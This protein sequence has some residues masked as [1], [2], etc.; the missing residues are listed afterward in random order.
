MDPQVL[1]EQLFFRPL[2]I[3]RMFVQQLAS[4]QRMSVEGNLWKV[5]LKVESKNTSLI[6]QPRERTSYFILED[7]AIFRCMSRA[8]IY[9]LFVVSVEK[10]WEK[11]SFETN[12]QIILIPPHT[13][14]IAVPWEMPLIVRS[15]S[16]L[17]LDR[18]MDG[19][20]AAATAAARKL[21]K[22]DKKCMRRAAVSL[23]ESVGSTRRWCDFRFFWIWTQWIE[24]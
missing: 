11:V 2:E 1:I 17:K 5:E 12:F 13:L 16:S 18:E 21:E 6:R 4:R 22:W 23:V 7:W 15:K 10:K 24:N 20:S 19:K 14:K 3:L 9:L 8:R